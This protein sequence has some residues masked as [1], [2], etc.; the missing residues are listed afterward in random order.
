MYPLQSLPVDLNSLM[1]DTD[2]VGKRPLSDHST[3]STDG[4]TVAHFRDLE[5]RLVGLI[6]H[7]DAVVGCVAWLTSEPILAALA[8]VQAVSIV[9]QKEDFLRPD[10]S[11]RPRWSRHLRELYDRLPATLDRY[12]DSIGILGGM[13]YCGDSTIEAVR[14]VGNHNRDH[15]PAW[16][17]SHHKFVVFCRLERNSGHEPR[18]W[19]ACRPVP[20]A[21]WTGSFNFTANAT[22]SFENAI[23]SR[24]PAIVAAYFEEWSQVCAL[25]E[26]LDWSSDWVEPE[27]RI[28]S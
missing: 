7:A 11:R 15:H 4:L 8:A 24:D 2:E 16:P 1:I 27:W 25:S 26:R 20:Y 23:Y 6:S 17:R 5:S 3:T 10:I 12:M 19:S 13:S 28:G 14:C 22:R 18:D 21:V 9:V